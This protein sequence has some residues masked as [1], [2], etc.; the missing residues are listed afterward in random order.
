MDEKVVAL[1]LQIENGF[2]RILESENH[3]IQSYDLE[4]LCLVVKVALLNQW[5]ENK[6]KDKTIKTRLELEGITRK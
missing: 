1:G 2:I 3:Y 5:M 6:P 4:I